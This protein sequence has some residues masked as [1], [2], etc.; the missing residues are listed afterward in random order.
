LKKEVLPF[1]TFNIL[2]SY[3]KSPLNWGLSYSWI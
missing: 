2:A 3:G 1:L